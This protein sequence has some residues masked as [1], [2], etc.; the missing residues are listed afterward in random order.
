MT[1]FRN[2]ITG[3]GT[4]S[5]LVHNGV[6]VDNGG[7]VARPTKQF[8]VH[9]QLGN[10]GNVGTRPDAPLK[11]M[12]AAFTQIGSGDTIHLNGKVAEQLVTPA[13][14][15]DVTVV[16][17]GN[18]PR[19]ADAHTSNNG[20]SSAQWSAPAS[21]GVAAQ[22]TVRVIQQGWT[23][24]NILFTAIDAN[25][26]MIELVR[27]SGSGDAERD[28]SHAAIIGCRFSGAGKG[29]RAGA[30]SYVEVVNHVLVEGCRFDNCTYG[31]HTAIISNYWTIRNNEFRVNT[32][33]I[34]ADLGYSF[35]SGNIMG[36]FTTDSIELPGGSA[37]LNVVT[38]NYLSG[39]Y[40]SAGGYTVSDANDE[41]GGNFNSLTG[42]TTAA[43]PG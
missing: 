28:A 32:N 19:H 23:F 12:A 29:I 21:G 39:T 11:T 34:V 25:A 3:V 42:G 31:I 30:T 24:S 14:V 43:D 16:G 9:G 37:G 40:S 1:N 38:L 35:I 15:F 6:T 10:D 22:A 7:S 33:H 20:Y 26:A 27:N 36:S 41:W 17:E 5:G 18:R 13:G 2:G 8:W 4:G